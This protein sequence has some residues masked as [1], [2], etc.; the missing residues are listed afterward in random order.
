MEDDL[1]PIKSMKT[2]KL[3]CL[4]TVNCVLDSTVESTFKKS[5]KHKEKL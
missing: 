4:C 1:K 3:K 5:I 2:H